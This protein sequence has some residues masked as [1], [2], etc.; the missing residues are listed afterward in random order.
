[1]HDLFPAETL[2]FFHGCSKSSF[3]RAFFFRNKRIES[4]SSVE[5][6]SKP[7]L[8]NMRSRSCRI[9]LRRSYVSFSLTDPLP[10]GVSARQLSR[11]CFRSREPAHEHLQ[12]A[13]L[14]SSVGQSARLVSV[15]SPVRTWVEARVF[16]FTPF[17]CKDDD[18]RKCDAVL[19]GHEPLGDA[20]GRA[21]KNMCLSPR[22][23]SSAATW[24]SSN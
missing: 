9:F 12:E 17:L 2:A 13:C 3:L 16:V 5:G 11:I 14:H 22:T 21:R 8:E 10:D 1:M 18:P 4:E 6:W 23:K 7:E 19:R 15:R 20:R 24:G